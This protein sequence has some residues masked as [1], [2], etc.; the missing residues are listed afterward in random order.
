M[1]PYTSEFYRQQSDLSRQSAE[2]IVPLVLRLLQP[3]SVVDVGCGVGTWLSAFKKYGVEDI[4]GIDGDYVNK[5]M[6]QIPE[7][8]FLSYDLTK[9]LDLDNKFDLVVSLEVAEH[10]PEECAK[11]FINSLVK[12]G[13]VVLFSAAIPFQGGTHHINEQWTEYWLEH[14]RDNGYEVIDA[15][16]KMI[17]HN[18]KIAF[19]YSQNLLIFATKTYIDSNQL[20][21]KEAENTSVSQL[22]IV[23]PQKYLQVI[24][25]IER[26]RKAY[27]SLQEIVELTSAEDKFILVDESQWESGN[28]IAGRYSIPFLE[29][30]GQYWGL[31]LNDETAISELERLRHQGAKFIVFA[32]NAFWWLEYYSAL[33]HYLRSKYQCVLENDRLVIF[34]L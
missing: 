10:L 14:F 3:R 26:M 18:D 6:L 28:S 31:P 7:D 20:L 23:H 30:E 27:D 34:A 24:S 9:P 21:K 8:R 4:L 19:W 25:E 12:L 1:Q 5:D 29:Q 13:E 2:E 11:T 17:W 15:L 32:W 22:S 33:H 16:R